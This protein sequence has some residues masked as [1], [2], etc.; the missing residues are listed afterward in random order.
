[1]SYLH[2]SGRPLGGMALGGMALGGYA[3]GYKLSTEEKERLMALQDLAKA[4]REARKARRAELLAT[5][6]S[7]AEA[8]AMLE[9]EARTRKAAKRGTKKPRAPRAQQ[10]LAI[11]G[12]VPVKKARKP[13]AK[14][15]KV[16]SLEEIAE[17]VVPE[18]KARKPRTHKPKTISKETHDAVKAASEKLVKDVKALTKLALK[19][20]LDNLGMDQYDLMAGYESPNEHMDADEMG[21]MAGGARHRRRHH[22]KKAAHHRRVGGVHGGFG[23]SDVWNVTKKVAP[24]ALTLL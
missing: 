2:Y 21:L 4:G 16:V 11:E 3:K 9:A 22:K 12:V 17:A 13:R 7:V 14:K 5:G 10:M 6:H 20:G 23:W 1:M 8:R 19:G 24:L 15:E 18:K